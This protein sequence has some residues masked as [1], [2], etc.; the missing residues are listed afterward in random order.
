MEI[1]G[2]LCMAKFKKGDLV[3]SIKIRDDYLDRYPEMINKPFEVLGLCNCWRNGKFKLCKKDPEV[4]VKSLF[5]EGALQPGYWFRVSDLIPLGK[6]TEI[7]YGRN[8][9]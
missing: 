1:T 5:K 3:F 8:K 4:K 7:L 9:F 6:S 2:K